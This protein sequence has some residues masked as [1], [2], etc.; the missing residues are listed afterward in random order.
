M[1]RRSSSTVCKNK[2]RVLIWQ[3]FL[4][5]VAL[6]AF[7]DWVVVLAVNETDLTITKIHEAAM[8]MDEMVNVAPA[9]FKAHFQRRGGK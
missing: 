8:G 6:L 4:K 3:S 5:C 1:G 2:A 9:P 7:L